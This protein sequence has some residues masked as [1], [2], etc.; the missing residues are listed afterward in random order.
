MWSRS[1]RGHVIMAFPSFDVAT[2]SWTPQADI[3]WCAGG[4]R[5]SEF[6][7]FSG[8]AGTE[9][10]AAS[11]ALQMGLVWIDQ[12]LKG[13]RADQRRDA[14]PGGNLLD[15]LQSLKGEASRKSLLSRLARPTSRPESLTFAQFKS[16]MAE[17][18]LAGSEPALRKSY[19]ALNR[20]RQTERPRWAQI[21]ERM[22][23]PGASRRIGPGAEKS[24]AARL[25]LTAR[26]WRRIV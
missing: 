7:R 25:P 26:D 14:K 19:A 21:A 20:L 24:R 9:N 10:E 18:G 22:R 13:L 8:Q 2:R 17:L 1:Y 12:R 23:N 15:A 16:I 5:D 6:V 4:T 3:S 11:A